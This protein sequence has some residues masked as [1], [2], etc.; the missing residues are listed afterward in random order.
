MSGGNQRLAS[1][2]VQRP[3]EAGLIHGLLSLAGQGVKQ[4]GCAAPW[5]ARGEVEIR[6]GAGIPCGVL[7]LTSKCGAWMIRRLEVGSRFPVPDRP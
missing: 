4:V 7:V 2:E 1:V 3:L 6:L 5:R